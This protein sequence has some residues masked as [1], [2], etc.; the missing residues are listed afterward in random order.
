MGGGGGGVC[1]CVWG[2]GGCEKETRVGSDQRAISHGTVP[3][4]THGC[5]PSRPE[6]SSPPLLVAT[7]RVKVAIEES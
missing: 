7:S 4:L 3:L 2:G 6:R 5:L 1:V